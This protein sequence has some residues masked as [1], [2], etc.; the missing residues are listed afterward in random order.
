[1]FVGKSDPLGSFPL[2]RREG[3]GWV[4]RGRQLGEVL[5]SIVERVRVFMRLVF[6]CRWGTYAG[7]CLGPRHRRDGVVAEFVTSVTVLFDEV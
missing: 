4:F 7:G 1:M 6:L 3:R 2:C 5:V